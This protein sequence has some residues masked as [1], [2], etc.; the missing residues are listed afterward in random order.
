MQ[1]LGGRR[2]LI[3]E[4]DPLIAMDLQ[5]ILED[6]GGVV[7]GPADSLASAFAIVQRDQ[8]DAAV[9]DVRLETG[10]S[11][12]LANLLHERGVPFLFQTSDPDLIQGLY[13]GVPVLRKPFRP[14]ELVAELIALVHNRGLSP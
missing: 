10:D 7:I 3:V 12:P 14:A 13:A 8:V 9:L 2:V 11:L 4:D 6:A 5:H 1:G